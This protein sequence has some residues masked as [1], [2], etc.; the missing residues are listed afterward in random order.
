MLLLIVFYREVCARSLVF[1]WQCGQQKQESPPCGC[2]PLPTRAVQSEYM[3]VVWLV[4]DLSELWLLKYI[5]FIFESKRQLVNMWRH[6]LKV[7]FG[8]HVQQA[9]R[10]NP[11]LWD[12]VTRTFDH[13]NLRRNSLHVFL[14]CCAYKK[15]VLLTNSDLDLWP[16]TNSFV[17]AHLRGQVNISTKFE[18]ISSRCSWDIRFKKWD[19][20]TDNPK[21]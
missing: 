1:R 16:V 21:T 4:W 6:F 12:Q 8:Y 11:V 5:Q 7:D 19:R 15:H 14:K 9:K 3:F 18:E 2:T 13:S 20:W 10:Q 17:S